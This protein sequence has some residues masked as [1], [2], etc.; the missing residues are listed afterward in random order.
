MKKALK[1]YLH[2]EES[3]VLREGQSYDD[4]IAALDDILRMV[5]S[6]RSRMVDMNGEDATDRFTNAVRSARESV[7]LLQKITKHE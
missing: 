7:A 1:A 4:Q 5:S 3:A 2:G 6:Q